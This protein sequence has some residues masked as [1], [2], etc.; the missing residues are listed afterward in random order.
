M[1]TRDEQ[2]ATVPRDR[3]RAR[4]LR[5]PLVIVLVAGAILRLESTGHTGP[6]DDPGMTAG[7]PAFLNALQWISSHLAFTIAVQHLLGLVTAALLYAT[8]RRAGAPRGLALVPA[9]VVALGGDF[10]Y[11]EHALLTESLWTALLAGSLYC[12][13]RALGEG[14]PWGWLAAGGALMAVS[15]TVRSPSLLLG[16]V[17]APWV[18]L[19]FGPGQRRRL[20]AAAALLVPFAVLVGAYAGAARIADGYAGF[21]D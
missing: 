19:A 18:L 5:H 7:Y 10:V 16:G 15:A 4:R 17:L 13:V 6:F 3:D 11:L 12:V 21:A 14:A 20:L 9:A 1:A 2:P 8:L